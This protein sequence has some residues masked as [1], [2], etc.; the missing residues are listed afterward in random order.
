MDAREGGEQDEMCGGSIL[1]FAIIDRVYIPFIA[2]N[3][4][5]ARIEAE[6]PR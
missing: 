2:V 6:G 4:L 5:C 3:K 1:S